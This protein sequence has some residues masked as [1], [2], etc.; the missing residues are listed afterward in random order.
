MADAKVKVA[1]DPK[2]Q[3][4]EAGARLARELKTISLLEEIR[5]LLAAKKP[6]A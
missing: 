2:L 1:E 5:D 3:G 4:Y 6:G